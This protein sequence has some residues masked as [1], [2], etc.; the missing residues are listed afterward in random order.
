MLFHSPPS[1]SHLRTFG[2]LCYATNSGASK[3]KFD[4]RATHCVF[5]GYPYAKRYK[6]YDLQ[7]IQLFVLRDVHFHED[8]FPFADNTSHP[9]ENVVIP[10]PIVDHY[11]SFDHLD[12]PPPDASPPLSMPSR[13]L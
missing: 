3:S 9:Y 11:T 10:N 5:L 4:A 7:T 1:F 2:C 8:I 13:A 6:L 12:V